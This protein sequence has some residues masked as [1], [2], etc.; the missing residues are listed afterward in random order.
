MS[1]TSATT[2]TTTSTLN[3]ILNAVNGTTGFDVSSAVNA[4]LYADRAPERTW[5]AQQTT[6]ASQT[7]AINTLNTD[8]ST[9]SDQLANLGGVT[10]VLN[11]ITVSSSDS[12]VLTASAADGTATGSHT[13]V[14]NNLAATA[15][16]YSSEQTSKTSTLGTGSF[17]ITTGGTT[18]TFQTG[19]GTS[20]DTL[21]DLAHVVNTAN[22]GLTATVVTDANGSRLSLV[23]NSPGVATN[24]SVAQSGGGLSF[25]QAQAGANA[26]LTVDGVPISSATNTVTGAIS[27][28]TLN[29]QNAAPNETVSLTLTPDT[30]DIQTAVSNF[31]IAY[32]QLV[33]DTSASVTYNSSTSAAGPLLSDSSAQNFY[34]DL[35]SASNYSGGS[36]SLLNTLTALGI[37]TT[38]K[39]TLTLNTATLNSALQ[40]N[41]SAVSEFFQGADGTGGFAAALTKTL[42]SYTDASSGAFTVDLNSIASESSDLTDQIN[43]LEIYVTSQQSILT[44]QYN[45]ADIALQQLT[46]TIKN[47]DALLGMNQNS[48][49]NG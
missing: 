40:S 45:N 5:Q 35:L 11:A 18:T 19:S 16:W 1:S 37:T 38:S 6:L 21:A 22:L 48:N 44:T 42:N 32:N 49:S 26:S 33:T 20:G 46:T 28:L 3:S 23:A 14:V 15:S 31:V 8:A 29:L 25:T 7:T 39:G 34:S 9:L 4:V 43:N 30:T 10:S 2:S 47:T 27:G 12:S 13:V 41:P 17:S 36:S 24:F